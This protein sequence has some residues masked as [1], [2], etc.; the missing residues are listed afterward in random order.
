MTKR[1]LS[2]LLTFILLFSA[3]YTAVWADHDCAGE[4]CPVCG[5]IRE[6]EHTLKTLGYSTITTLNFIILICAVHPLFMP[7]R[8][9]LR[10]STPVTLKVKLSN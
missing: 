2:L 5:Q 10:K 8:T 7:L 4:N 9:P 3:F 6:Y 1:N